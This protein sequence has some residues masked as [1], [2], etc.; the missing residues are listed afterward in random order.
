[1]SFVVDMKAGVDGLALHIGN[2]SCNVD[3]CHRPGHYRP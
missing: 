1:M 3:D 2:E